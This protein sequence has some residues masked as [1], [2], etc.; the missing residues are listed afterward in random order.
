LGIQGSRCDPVEDTLASLTKAEVFHELGRRPASETGRDD[1]GPQCRLEP[2]QRSGERGNREL[3]LQRLAD[4]GPTN[5]SQDHPRQL[6]ESQES[7]D[8]LLEGL[9][10]GLLAISCYTV[11]GACGAI[12]CPVMSRL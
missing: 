9:A 3:L 10:T 5:P 6:V 4:L 12:D 7:E 1:G 2:V 8:L 11:A